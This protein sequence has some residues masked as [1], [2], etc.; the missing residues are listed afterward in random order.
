MG[1]LKI[2]KFAIDLHNLHAA[3]PMESLEKYYKVVEE[4][5]GAVE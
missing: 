3:S 1:Q 4:D 5:K 2:A